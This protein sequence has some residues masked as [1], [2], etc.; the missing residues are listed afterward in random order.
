MIQIKFYVKLFGH[1]IIKTICQS[2]RNK[3]RKHDSI[4]NRTS[5]TEKDQQKPI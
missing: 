2:I 1:I 5:K 4:G 3:I